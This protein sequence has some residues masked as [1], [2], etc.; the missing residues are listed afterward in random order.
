MTSIAAM[1]N[2]RTLEPELL[3]RMDASSGE[4]P[5]GRPALS[6]RQPAAEAAAGAL[7]RQTARLGHWGTTPGQ[8][9][10]YVHL[11]GPAGIT[12]TETAFLTERQIS[13]TPLASAVVPSRSNRSDGCVVIVWGRGVCC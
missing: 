6:V 1:P 8:N 12:M 5:V 4:L 10:I 13:D 9:F 7:G 2:T 3:H 11:T